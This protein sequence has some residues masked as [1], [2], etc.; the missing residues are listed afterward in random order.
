MRIQIVR[1]QLCLG[2][3]IEDRQN[4]HVAFFDPLLCIK[5]QTNPFACVSIKSKELCAS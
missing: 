5:D 3:Q 4:E 2:A 1:S